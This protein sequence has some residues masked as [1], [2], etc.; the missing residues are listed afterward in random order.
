MSEQFYRAFEDKHR[1]SRALIKAR[2]SVYLPF[3]E[4]L[5]KIYP[6]AQA[7][8]LGCGRGEWLELLGESGFKVR[9]VDMDEGMLEAC[10]SLNLNAELMDALTALQQLPAQSQAVVSGFHIAEHIPFDSLL[11]LVKEA[12]RVLLPAGLLIFETPNPEN[13]IVG[14]SNFYLDP[15]HTKPLPSLL[16]EFLPEFVGGFTKIKTI[17]LQ[18]PIRTAGTEPVLLD[19]FNG[20]SPDY[21]MIAQR[22][23]PDNVAAAVSDAFFIEKGVT[24]SLASKKFEDQL[25]LRLLHIERRA[26]AAFSMAQHAEQ[27]LASIY[28]STSWRIT[29]PIRWMGQQRRLLKE[30]GV[31]VR[32]KALVKKIFRLVISPKND[33][34]MSLDQ[35]YLALGPSSEKATNVAQALKA[36]IKRN[37]S[38]TNTPTH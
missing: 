16:L 33:V 38:R 26:D 10:Q 20:V 23:A 24:L 37:P 15:T 28:T 17:G 21:A 5:L 30:Q 27:A 19:V 22:E 13:L 4:P 6:Q 31:L 25:R 29:T 36:E 35:S 18:E 8:D 2:L 12:R 11:I 14:T 1:G 32:A 34:E 9:G 3:V 7:I